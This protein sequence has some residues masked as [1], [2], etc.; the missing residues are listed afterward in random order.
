[1]AALAGTLPIALGLGAG[2]NSR[3]PLGL[4]VVGGLIVSQLITV[5][6]TPVYYTYLDSF[7]RWATSLFRRRRAEAAAVGEPAQIEMP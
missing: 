7:Q 6:I 1:M 5:Y 4:A 3:R 2:A